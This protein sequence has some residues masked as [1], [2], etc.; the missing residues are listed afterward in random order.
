MQGARPYLEALFGNA[1]PGFF[2]VVWTSPAKQTF[3]FP[4]TPDGIDAALAKLGELDNDG[5]QN[6]YI[7]QYL[8]GE[9]P[10]KGRGTLADVRALCSFWIDIDIAG[11]AHKSATAYPPSVSEALRIVEAMPLRPSAVINSG[12]G[13]H[14]YWFFPE[15]LYL[16]S[17]DAKADI[18]DLRDR[19]K[20]TCQQAA[21]SLGYTVDSVW[22]FTRVL[23]CP[24]SLNVKT[25]PPIRSSI[26]SFD[27][28]I[29]YGE[30]DLDP[31][32][33]DKPDTWA[34]GKPAPISMEGIDLRYLTV[35]PE[36][37]QL[38]LEGDQKFRRTWDRKRRDLEDQ[39]ASGYSF[40]IAIYLVK[41]GLTDEQIV[42]LLYTWRQDQG[43]QRKDD[44]WYAKTVGRARQRA[45]IE[46][47]T[48]EF[49]DA[50]SSGEVV[51]RAD[52]L[53]GL[54]QTL[55][56]TIDRI[57]LIDGEEPTYRV[58]HD[59]V[60]RKIGPA[61]A[62]LSQAKFRERIAQFRHVLKEFKREA[63]REVATVFLAAAEQR[64]LGE[65]GTEAGRARAWV[66]KFLIDRPPSEDT[67]ARDAFAGKRAFHHNGGVAIFG[68]AL[69]SYVRDQFRA[70]QNI[71]PADFDQAMEQAGCY[72]TEKRWN[73]YPAGVRTVVRAWVVPTEMLGNDDGED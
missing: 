49:F 16:D 30:S 12:N 58:T 32:L 26:L 39:S 65:G 69:L 21:S 66:A 25:K 4:T 36:K 33:L 37:V 54:S 61:S 31:F 14:A 64:D 41:L 63:W 1:E 10:K 53:K 38:A 55:E 17:D 59:G 71:T 34:H 43:A 15:P 18:T 27:P 51:E 62:V 42:Q 72:L 7:G 35:K 29:Q 68:D 46:S 22:D 11:P 6:V 60:S 28:L 40:A 24:L 2:F 3:S 23:R 52:M 67:A 19:W 8:L 13:L 44:L 73:F 70:E 47:Q 9:P 5:T 57:E 56:F 20:A 50:F 45:G 48:A